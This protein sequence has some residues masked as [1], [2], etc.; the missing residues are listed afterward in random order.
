MNDY[1]DAAITG[2]V[3]AVLTAIVSVIGYLQAQAAVAV[4]PRLKDV[5]FITA[6]LT[7]HGHDWLFYHVPIVGVIAAG[8]FALIGTVLLLRVVLDV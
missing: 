2:G 5:G 4:R 3:W 1:R 8:G 7:G 6:M